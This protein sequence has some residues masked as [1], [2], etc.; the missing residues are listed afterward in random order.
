VTKANNTMR[1]VLTYGHEL[2]REVR[3]EKPVVV[4]GRDPSCD[5]AIDDITISKRHMKLEYVGGELHVEDLDS[6]NGLKV[7]GHLTKR[8]ALQHLDVIQVGG[9]RMHV[10]DDE[11]LPAVKMGPESTVQ[12]AIPPA[13]EPAPDKT[14]KI[15]LA[16]TQPTEQHPVAPLMGLKRV[17]DG[18][19]I[20]RLDQP[21]NPIGGPS[22]QTAVLAWRR[23]TLYLSRLSRDTLRVNGRDVGPGSSQIRAGDVI[24]VGDARY[25]VVTVER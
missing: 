13:R 23:D 1:V 19:A 8:Q 6:T 14:A 3:I 18:S 17:G 25:L 2:L 15:P 4:V 21:N 20:Q 7:N 11:M 24:E 12:T 5:I 10:F 22:G 9:H 16:D